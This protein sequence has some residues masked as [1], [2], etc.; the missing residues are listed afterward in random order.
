MASPML[1]L[2]N[3]FAVYAVDR[4]VF[5]SHPDGRPGPPE[6]FWLAGALFFSLLPDLDAVAGVLGGDMGRYHNQ[7]LHSLPLALLCAAILAGLGV[8]AGARPAARAFRLAAAGA[9]IHLAL[10]TFTA[11]RGVMLLWPWT[12]RRFL[13]DPPLL[14]GLVW[15]EGLVSREHL[16]TFLQEL[17][18]TLG[19]LAASLLLLVRRPVQ[20][21]AI[22]REPAL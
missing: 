20:I 18:W 21:L 14:R 1:H 4:A 17:P 12:D 3:G 7:I 8:G 11:G 9:L 16:R 2:A 13:S 22:R 10:D 15:S 6:P 5:R 19:L